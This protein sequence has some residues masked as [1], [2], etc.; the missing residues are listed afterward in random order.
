MSKYKLKRTRTGSPNV[1]KLLLVDKATGKTIK[2]PKQYEAR[3]LVE[4]NGKTK[5]VAECFDDFVEARNF[6]RNSREI[7]VE[8]APETKAPLEETPLFKDIFD[9][10][11]ENELSQ[12][13]PS[14]MRTRLSRK[15]HLKFFLRLSVRMND[16]TPD[17]V[18]R[19]LKRIRDERYLRHQHSTRT[20]YGEEFKLLKLVLTYYRETYDYR[21]PMPLL[22]RHR[23][24]L[25]VRVKP[26][27]HKKDLTIEEWRKWTAE[28]QGRV[29]RANARYL[30]A[31]CE[32]EKAIALEAWE[33]E[34]RVHKI[35]QLQ[36][37]LLG[38]GQ[39]IPALHLED[40]NRETQEITLQRRCVWIRSK[41][42]E[43]LVFDGLKNGESK[44]IY[45]PM[46][47]KIILEWAMAE[48]IRSG[49]LFYY[50]GKPLSYRQIEY[51]YTKAFKALGLAKSATHVVRHGSGTELHR[52]SG[53]D[54]KQ[55]QKGLGHKN[56][57]T[58]EVYIGVRDDEFRKSMAK[59]DEALQRVSQ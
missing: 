1:Y 44:T 10:W 37:C 40:V 59:M 11:V 49:P 46:A 39:E 38:R 12:G 17:F 6:A 5:R 3:R 23:K 13:S 41:S 32:R 54:M 16:I 31:G 50:M 47:C 4:K 48:G 14:S 51:R 19:W 43:C 25:V 56:I 35:A 24:K 42:G 15:R 2:P 26:K 55:A 30:I 20:S 29:E 9:R 8:K 53:G 28:L 45:S 27:P 22:K 18:D 58:T 21:F 57:T 7:I 36:Y 52:A 33:I 34:R